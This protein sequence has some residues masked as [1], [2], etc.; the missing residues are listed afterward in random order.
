MKTC[1]KCQKPYPLEDFHNDKNAKDGKRSQCRHCVLAANRA[2]QA[3]DPERARAAWR[4]SFLKNYDTKK[5]RLKVIESYG[6]TEKQYETLRQIKPGCCHICEK[7]FGAR[8]NIDHCHETGKVRGLL[9][10]RCNT[11]IGSFDDNVKVMK[12]AI[13]YVEQQG[14]FNGAET[15]ADG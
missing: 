15:T 6:L 10:F 12:R 11:A 2:W 13:E 14:F 1:T 4:K 5:R 3:K 8:E 9:C 7:P